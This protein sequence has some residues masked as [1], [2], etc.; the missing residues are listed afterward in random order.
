[1]PDDDQNP[2]VHSLTIKDKNL[3]YAITSLVSVFR[4]GSEIELAG[5]PWTREERLG[6]ADQIAWKA[7]TLVG[8][9]LVTPATVKPLIPCLARFLRQEKS[10]LGV[11][12]ATYWA[13]ELSWSW[14]GKDD[15]CWQGVLSLAGNLDAIA[16]STSESLTDY[17]GVYVIAVCSGDVP[18]KGLADYYT[19]QRRRFGWRIFSVDRRKVD[20]FNCLQSDSPQRGRNGLSQPAA[21]T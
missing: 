2:R 13:G 3:D 15:T 4:N 5:Q 6:T 18:A 17:G 7:A 16:K 1:M 20:P 9:R 11:V 21:S 12:Q 8:G 19:Q 14:I 10:G